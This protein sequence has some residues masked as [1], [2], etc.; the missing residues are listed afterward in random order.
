MVIAPGGHSQ[1]SRRKQPTSPLTVERPTRPEATPKARPADSHRSVIPAKPGIQA[2]LCLPGVPA[3]HEET[4]GYFLDFHFRGNDLQ[5]QERPTRPERAP[6]ARPGGGGRNKGLC[7]RISSSLYTVPPGQ[8]GENRQCV[9]IRL[10]LLPQ[11]LFSR[12]I[13]WPSTTFGAYLVSQKKPP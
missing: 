2:A 13:H 3:G 6:K 7:P 1:A 4:L 8:M 5:R 12:T 10:K 9:F 11:S